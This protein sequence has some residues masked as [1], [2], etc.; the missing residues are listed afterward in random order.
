MLQ[1][2]P[3]RANCVTKVS[4][5]ARI[6]PN[7]TWSARHVVWPVAQIQPTAH[8]R[9]ESD[10]LRSSTR[11]GERMLPLEPGDSSTHLLEGLHARVQHAWVDVRIGWA[12][13][14][15]DAKERSRRGLDHLRSD[16][17]PELQVVVG[18]NLCRKGQ[19]H[20]GGLGAWLISAV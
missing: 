20:E 1:I 6:V 15:Y 2:A 7:G 14:L 16:V 8:K 9:L 3:C 18:H 12:H 17:P 4:A 5:A 13:L 10:L 19:K 11:A